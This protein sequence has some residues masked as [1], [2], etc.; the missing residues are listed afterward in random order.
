MILDT[1]IFYCFFAVVVL[2]FEV[3][4]SPELLSLLLP[5]LPWLPWFN[6]DTVEAI[7]LEFCSKVFAAFTFRLEMCFELS[8]ACCSVD[9]MESRFEKMMLFV[10]L[11][12]K[13][14]LSAK[15]LTSLVYAFVTES[16][17]AAK[18]VT[19]LLKLLLYGLHAD[20]IELIT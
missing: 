20:W 13:T 9:F 6:S 16:G 8:L 11:I 17:D 15:L 18:F 1:V 14:A 3:L 2:E 12:A 10:S 7:C 5:W 19:K 4:L